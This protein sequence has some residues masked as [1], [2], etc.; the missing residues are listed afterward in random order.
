MAT[1]FAEEILPFLSLP[2]FFFFFFFVLTVIG[3]S[4]CRRP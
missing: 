4:H 1:E 3:A 2:F